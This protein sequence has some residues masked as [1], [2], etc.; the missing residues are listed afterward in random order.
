[1]NWGAS[2]R[3]GN[4][5]IGRGA[6]ADDALHAVSGQERIAIDRVGLLPDAVNTAGAL[7]QPDDR[8]RQIEIDDSGAM[9]CHLRLLSAFTQRGL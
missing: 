6:K 8:P 9:L 2:A 1:M 4:F 7:N 3:N 5:E